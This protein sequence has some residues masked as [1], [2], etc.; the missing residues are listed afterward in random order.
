M[1]I[2]A[3]LLDG[4]DRADQLALDNAV[5]EPRIRMALGAVPRI[6]RLS[7]LRFRLIDGIG[8]GRGRQGPDPVADTLESGMIDGDGGYARA[9]RRAQVALVH[10]VVVAVPVQIHAVPRLLVPQG[11]KVRCGNQLAQRQPIQWPVELDA[12]VGIEG[13]DAPR[14]PLGDVVTHDE[15]QTLR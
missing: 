1:T 6:E 15:R 13:V 5:L 12:L 7:V 3:D 8:V 10:G 14:S 11:R 2:G 4:L 9:E